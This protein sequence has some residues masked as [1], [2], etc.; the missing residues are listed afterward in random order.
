MGKIKTKRL[1]VQ[2]IPRPREHAPIDQTTPSITHISLDGLLLDPRA[3]RR[4]LQELLECLYIVDEHLS[5]LCNEHLQCQDSDAECTST[6]HDVAV[7][8]AETSMSFRSIVT[9]ISIVQDV[10]VHPNF[11]KEFY[12]ILVMFRMFDHF[13]DEAICPCTFEPVMARFFG[14]IHNPQRQPHLYGR[15]ETIIP[16]DYRPL[17]SA[18]EFTMDQFLLFWVA[19][20]LTM[21]KN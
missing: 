13:V 2:R 18:H 10:L 16:S 3:R 14:D 19:H 8:R 4:A 15:F 20:S 11:L 12:L 21:T 9:S 7:A 5:R 1:R 6:Q 17:T